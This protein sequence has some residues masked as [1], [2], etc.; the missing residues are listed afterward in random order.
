M[1]GNTAIFVDLGYLS[2]ITKRFGNTKVDYNKL[3]ATVL[4]KTH[5]NHYRTYVYHCPPYQGNPPTAEEKLRKSKYDR[6]IF[7][8]SRT[9]RLILRAGRL[10]KK[11]NTTFI[12]K[13]VDTYFAIDLVKL[14]L[15]ETIKTAILI[16]GDS[17]FVPAIKEAKEQG[18]V[19]KTYYYPG[20]VHSTLQQAS[21]EMIEI[22]PEFLQS[23]KLD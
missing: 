4:D 18:V 2:Y 12:Q 8:L 6:Y 19:V 7:S 13:G 17:D 3:P 23:I 15:R 16:A 10:V 14:S 5:E 9:N 11:G 1:M 21:D 22:T 20:T